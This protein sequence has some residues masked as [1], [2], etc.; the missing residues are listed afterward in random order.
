MAHN[1]SLTNVN[2]AEKDQK[3]WRRVTRSQ[4]SRILGSTRKHERQKDKEVPV[5]IASCEHMGA[6]DS[7]VPELRERKGRTEARLNLAISDTKFHSRN[8]E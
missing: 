1:Y 4:A 3:R 2:C 5:N 7:L 8:T 6:I